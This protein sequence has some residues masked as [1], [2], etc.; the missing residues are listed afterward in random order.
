M[1]S[2]HK[3][4]QHIRKKCH[5][6][7]WITR[8]ELPTF[9][10]S[11]LEGRVWGMVSPAEAALRWVRVLWLAGGALGFLG[12]EEGA[13]AEVGMMAE[14]EEEEEEEVAGGDW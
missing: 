8:G 9:I 5:K 2:S 3:L 12:G 11:R 6:D 7:R 10:S 4:W 13:V 1:M 14:E